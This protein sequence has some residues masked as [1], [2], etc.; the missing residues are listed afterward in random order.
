MVKVKPSAFGL[1]SWNAKLVVNAC[2]LTG[3]VQK[4]LAD[5]FSAV[6]SVSCRCVPSS[7]VCPLNCN[8]AAEKPE[9]KLTAGVEPPPVLMVMTD[10]AV[11]LVLKPVSVAMAWTVVVAPTTKGAVY[12]VEP[13][14]GA[15]PLVV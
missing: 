13:V 1:V 5:S 12:F 4:A 2:T 3:V 11:A 14:P 8:P 7:L 9:A 6:V 10:C 15:V